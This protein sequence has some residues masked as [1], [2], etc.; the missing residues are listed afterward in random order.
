VA[1]DTLL[2]AWQG[3][4]G[5]A[6]AAACY[7]AFVEQALGQPLS[8]PFADAIDGWILGSQ[9]FADRIRQQLQPAT[10]RSGQRRAI[11]LDELLVIVTTHFGI[12]PSQLATRRSAHPARPVF[13]YLAKRHADA[14]LRE[15][16]PLLGLAR[17]DCVP[18]LVKR[19]REAAP[20]SQIYCAIRQI[21]QQL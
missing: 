14:T 16:A 4:F 13:A 12:P 1:Y 21:E 15:M 19:A 8:D 3:A 20:D 2:S 17:A 5:R 11:H 18:H 9:A 6:D 7:Q 10:R